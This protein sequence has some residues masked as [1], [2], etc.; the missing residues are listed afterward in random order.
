[1]IRL[2]FACT[3]TD[4]VHVTSPL[5]LVPETERF[6][7]PLSQPAVVLTTD[8]GV[9]H[10]YA[11]NER[12]LAVA[13]GFT[14]GRDRFFQVDL[15][16]RLALGTLSEL[17]GDVSLAADA[18]S[19]SIGMTHATDLVLST[20]PPSLRA[21][22]EGYAAGLNAYIDAVAAGQLPAPSE[23]D[24]AAPLLGATAPVDVMARFEA[25]DV[26]AIGGAVLYRLGYETDDVGRAADLSALA[27]VFSGEAAEADRIAAAEALYGTLH[28]VEAIASA[29]E[30]TPARVLSTPA[31]LPRPASAERTLVDRL[32]ARL[33]RWQ[34]RMGR[35]HVDGWGSNA[36][37]VSGDHTPDGRSLLAADG[38]LE[39]DIPALM[40]QV[41]LDTAELGGGDTT[42]VGMSIVGIPVLAVGTNGRVAWS[43]TQ[44][45]GD[46]TDW[47][48]EQLQLGADGRPS[49]ALWQGT[50]TPLVA[51][52]ETY[53]VANVP[54]LGSVG[55]TETWTR[56]QLA[57]GRW[58]ADAEG[59]VLGDGE[60]PGP[61]EAVVDFAGVRVV[62]GDVDG[63]GVVTGVSFDFGGLDPGNLM[64]LFD[65]FAHSSDVDAIAE[66]T[67]MA[68][69][70]SQN[71][72]A[73]DAD[74]RIL[75][76]GYQ[77][78][79]C[80]EA[81]RAADGSWL[82]G[83]DPQTLLDGT[84]F[85]GFT[86]PVDAGLAVVED[87]AEPS[88]CVVPWLDTP[89]AFDPPQGYLLT[90][91]NDPGGFSFDDRLTDG[92]VYM[93]GPWDDGFRARTIH[94]GLAAAVA[95]GQA[96][97][98][99]MA[100]LQAD[101]HS[102]TAV[103]LAPR[104]LDAIDRAALLG[105]PTSEVDARIED[106]WR[107]HGPRLTEAAARIDAWLAS[108]ALARSGVE[109]FY[110]PVLPGDAEAS[111]ATMIWNTW[112][113]DLTRLA[114]DDEG[115]PGATFRLGGS[116][117][118][119]RLLHEMLDEDNATFDV[120]WDLRGTGVVESAD[121][122]VITSLVAALD[123][124]ASDPIDGDE[125][126][127]GTD[128]M[129]AWRWGYRHQVEFQSLVLSYLDDPLLGALLTDFAVDTSDL[130][131]VAGLS[132][133]DARAD[134]SWF[135]RHG[136]NRNVDAANNGL[137]GR[138]FRYGSGPVM[139]MVF[140]LGPDALSGQNVLPGGQSG[141]LDSP[142]TADQAAL[143][144]ANDVLPVQLAVNDVVAA[145]QGRT[146]LL[147]E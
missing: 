70:L 48:A 31:P 126:G 3:A 36:W 118:R 108:G 43:T 142:H 14:V 110:D 15:A 10:I 132:P 56:W 32:R 25:R 86:L 80:R 139:R 124:L 69:A 7:L 42:S 146:T 121:E 74:G 63:D 90:A 147:P 138:S 125:G 141:L 136:D 64:A 71:L 104:L 140:A 62:P 89:H 122:I 50:W 33:D 100:T 75:Y 116:A 111:V 51:I 11:A 4:D 61:G 91:N 28:P 129:D 115:L 97:I 99:D 127:F 143:W 53:E 52:D 87:H 54:A 82:D 145:A 6:A 60:L 37:A 2:W 12:D 93:G 96:S 47:Y 102:P 38:H 114:I 134:L 23:Y 84:R 1:M 78:T 77:I 55:R 72:I 57:D 144:L 135:P 30:W 67:R 120:F 83:G 133:S 46:V 65:A 41:G 73:A 35:D 112:L 66:A 95:D 5:S 113:G 119:L 103:L 22:F 39:L 94:D 59:R 20:A 58:L 40:Y 109:T 88:H 106:L 123:F 45:S 107:V 68:Q 76:S 117:T 130:P 137:S 131:L 92:A 16:R 44:L 13:F 98:A 27:T 101:H 79:P 128:D 85:G 49:A 105:G 17:L 26:A 24:L 29:P 9:P 34:L 8:G 19:R 18:E 21:T 81:L